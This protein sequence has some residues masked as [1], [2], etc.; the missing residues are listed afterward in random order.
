MLTSPLSSIFLESH[1]FR[2]G[3]SKVGGKFR[4]WKEVDAS[5]GNYSPKPQGGPL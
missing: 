2:V 4:I 3:V 5:A 1:L